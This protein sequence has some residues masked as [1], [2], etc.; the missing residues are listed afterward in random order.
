[1]LGGA[2]VWVWLVLGL[3]LPPRGGAL[4]LLMSVLTLHVLAWGAAGA[5]SLGSGG[6]ARQG[7]RLTRGIPGN[8][9]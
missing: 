4:N 5:E 1:M 3:R 9:R 7:P 6:L 8:A 2:L